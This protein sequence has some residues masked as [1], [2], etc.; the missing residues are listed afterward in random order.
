MVFPSDAIKIPRNQHSTSLYKGLPY[1]NRSP[2]QV[3]VNLMEVCVCFRAGGAS[4]A[5]CSPGGCPA[6]DRSW[7]SRPAG[8]RR[9]HTERPAGG[10]RAPERQSRIQRELH[11][12]IEGS[13]CVQM[14]EGLE[15]NPK[16]CVQ[17]CQRNF[18]S[19]KD[20]NGIKKK[21]RS[22]KMYT[23]GPKFGII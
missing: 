9:G 12:T 19:V 13:V 15:R 3:Q 17:D 21:K 11:M 20:P 6:V 14:V 8:Q 2:D 22:L 23:T 10:C 5:W 4:E 1:N 18:L 7:P 16:G